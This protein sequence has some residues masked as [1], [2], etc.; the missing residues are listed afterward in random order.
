MPKRQAN[1]D[2][3]ALKDNRVEALKGVIKDIMEMD[4]EDATRAITQACPNDSEELARQITI[5]AKVDDEAESEEDVDV[6]FVA[7]LKAYAV[8][9]PAW[10]PSVTTLLFGI[11]VNSEIFVEPEQAATCIEALEVVLGRM[12]SNGTYSDALLRPTASDDTPRTM[13][14]EITEATVPNGASLPVCTLIDMAESDGAPI[15]LFNAV[16]RKF[17]ALYRQQ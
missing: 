14:D 3:K 2:I 5:S 12:Y 1:G 6:A 4:Q 11:V 13:A 7:K 15:W 17:L 16:E 10:Q 9:D 8:D